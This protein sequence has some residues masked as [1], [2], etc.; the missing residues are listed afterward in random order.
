MLLVRQFGVVMC[1][2]HDAMSA[3]SIPIPTLAQRDGRPPHSSLL[4]PHGLGR[5]E[6]A[7]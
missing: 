4:A 7:W 2:L 5:V 6:K 3:C 1:V